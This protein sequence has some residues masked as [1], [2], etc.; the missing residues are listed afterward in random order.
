MARQRFFSPVIVRGEEDQGV[1]IWGYGKMAYEK[2]L[3]LV[4]NPEYG[5]I[6]DPEEGTDLVIDYGKPAGATFP[7]TKI[8]PRRKSSPIVEDSTQVET[9][10][11][12]IPDFNDIFDRKT[13]EQ[14]GEI[15]EQYLSGG[16]DAESN[17][18]EETKYAATPNTTGDVSEVDAAFNDLLGS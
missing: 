15:L 5:D 9:Y 11:E 1:R 10:L 17:S 4:L 2:L 13:P 7:Q 16:L 8:T 12:S 3:S 18:V 6:T 14:V